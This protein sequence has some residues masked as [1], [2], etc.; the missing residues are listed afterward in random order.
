MIQMPFPGVTVSSCRELALFTRSS[1]LALEKNPYLS[2][3]VVNMSG[4][5]T[6]MKQ[7]SSVGEVD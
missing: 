3:V 4:V 6:M 5:T 7:E 1:I 2:S